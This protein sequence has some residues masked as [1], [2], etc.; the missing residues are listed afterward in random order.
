MHLPDD[1]EY[2]ARVKYKFKLSEV[3]LCQQISRLQPYK[4]L[5]EDGIPNVV[6]KQMTDLIVPYLIQIFHTVFKLSTYSN[7][8]HMWNTIMLCK[9]GKP[10]YNIPKAHQPIT[11]MNTI[12]KFLSFIIMEDI[13]Y[14]CERHGLVPNTHSEAGQQEYLRCDA[15]SH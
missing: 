4:V 6:L 12:R 8:W 11:L 2:L 10:R 7:S 14:M 3:Q 9:P 1:P 5:G 13:T 15:L